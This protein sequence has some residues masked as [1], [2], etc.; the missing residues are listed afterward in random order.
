[1]AKTKVAKSK[2]QRKPKPIYPVA[3][4]PGTIDEYYWKHPEI[5]DQRLREAGVDVEELNCLLLSGKTV[6]VRMFDGKIE[7]WAEEE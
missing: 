3:I 4:K 1:M 6:K 2:R 5:V 7:F